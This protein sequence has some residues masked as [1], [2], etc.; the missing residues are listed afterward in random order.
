MSKSK[1]SVIDYLIT[2]SYISIVIITWGTNYPLMKL[3]FADIQP[4]TFGALRLAGGAFFIFI[5]LGASKNKKIIPEKQEAFTLAYISILQFVSVIG[6]AGISLLFL[7]AG[8]TIT[9]IYTMPLWVTLFSVFIAKERPKLIQIIGVV[10]SLLGILLFLDPTVIDWTD[11]GAAIG[12]ILALTAA[13]MWGLG[14]VLYKKHKWQSSVLSQSFWQLLVGSVFLAV[15]ALIF[16]QQDNINYSMTMII[17]LIWNCIGPTSVSV[18]AWS[19]V[20]NRISATIASQ[21]I[22]FTPFVGIA[23]SSFIFNED[24]PPAFAISAVLIAIGGALSLISKK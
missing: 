22:M 20:L 5:L 10:L 16:E 21:F 9:A 19:K 17:I 13:L 11:R 7:Q 8:R 3:A 14:A 18:W 15:F 2:F 24:L 1:V 6:F 4:L 12:M 23:A